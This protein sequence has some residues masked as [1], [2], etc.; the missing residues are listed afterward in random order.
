GSMVVPGQLSID[1]SLDYVKLDST[2]AGLTVDTYL[3]SFSG[4]DIEVIGS[5]SGIKAKVIVS[6][7]STD[8]TSTT[9]WVKYISSG[10]STTSGTVKTFIPGEII[11]TNASVPVYASVKNST[12]AI[13]LGSS[14]NIQKGVYFVN[15]R[16]VLVQEQTII[17]DAYTNTPTYR[18]GLQITEDFIS[19]EEDSSLYDNAQGSTNYAAPGAHRYYIDLTLTK[20]GITDTTD[21]SFIELLRVNSGLLE[22]V[23]TQTAYS[24]IEDSIAR[25]TYDE[26]GN[27][28]VKDFQY[29]VKEHRSNDRG[30]WVANTNYLVGDIVSYGG[31]YYRV[32]TSGN[33]GLTAPNHTIGS[34]TNGG[35][36]LTVET[37]PFFNQGV[38]TVDNGG[39][40]TSM[41]VQV[42]PGKGYVYG[43]EIEKIGTTT[44]KVPKA[45]TFKGVRNATIQT[46][47]GS[48][49]K[50][51]NIFGSLDVTSF[52][53]V[54]LRDSFVSTGG[55]APGNEIGTARV[56]YIEYDSGTI[57]LNTCQYVLSLY[58]IRMN[59]GYDFQRNVFAISFA[60][61]GIA[62]FTCDILKN[63]SALTGTI[64]NVTNSNIITG[65]GTR[66]TT[67]LK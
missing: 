52:P 5:T 18:V 41:A 51:K 37:N 62:N 1:T 49:I 58:D 9:L 50:I 12:D 54:S 57:G 10:N 3:S 46:D 14:A 36:V 11:Y 35:I 42:E 53:T 30:A 38:Y 17:L 6:K 40:A 28:V 29:H 63:T 23:V 24:L 61:S 32:E 31:V 19:P 45:T 15:G 20:Y 48:Y 43:Y 21:K 16:F 44:V 33:S 64:T 60:N 27:Y 34:A 13:G 67:E 47:I 4:Q 55:T 59:S 25:R 66:F 56:R 39:D 2:Y 26:S 8:S 7:A 65:V 22:S